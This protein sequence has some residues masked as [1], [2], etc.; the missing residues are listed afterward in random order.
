M[1][2][3]D[4]TTGTIHGTCG[5]A[6]GGRPLT[7]TSQ[8][9]LTGARPGG[10]VLTHSGPAGSGTPLDTIADMVASVA[11]ALGQD[12]IS[13]PQYAA[14]RRAHPEA[15]LMGAQN[16]RRRFGTWNAALAAAGLA[17]TH[18][19][20]RDYRGQTEGDM[21]V[22]LATWLRH[23][24]TAGRGYVT[25]TMAEYVQWVADHPD[26]PCS[27]SLSDHGFTTLRAQAAQMEE[28]MEVLPTPRPVARYGQ[29][30]TS[31]APAA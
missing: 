3:H 30:K 21:V 12:T 8:A 6:A 20:G 23:Y 7:G 14:Y 10:Y 29:G 26:A 9:S 19:V 5:P 31:Q 2:I 18:M 16:V 25:A 13:Q 4:H 22:W 27:Q 17:V 15:N 24:R 11:V 1:L 28:S